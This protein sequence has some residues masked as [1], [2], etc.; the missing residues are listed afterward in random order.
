MAGTFILSE[1]TI[2]PPTSPTSGTTSASDNSASSSDVDSEH[3]NYGDTIP[4]AGHPPPPPS[5]EADNGNPRALP[6]DQVQ[7]AGFRPR[8]RH[9]HGCKAHEPAR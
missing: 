6:R 2:D 4:L 5:E 8:S 7:A 3:D 9:C 1:P